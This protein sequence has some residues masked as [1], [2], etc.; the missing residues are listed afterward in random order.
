MLC[1]RVLSTF[2]PPKKRF[3]LP[4]PFTKHL[5]LFFH[6]VNLAGLI[7]LL[8]T[9]PRAWIDNQSG[10]YWSSWKSKTPGLVRLVVAK[11][12][13]A[14]VPTFQTLDDPKIIGFLKSHPLVA[15]MASQDGKVTLIR[16][17]GNFRAPTQKVEEQT[18]ARWLQ[19]AIRSGQESWAP[20]PA[21]HPDHLREVL[22]IYRNGPW[23]VAIRWSIGSPEVEQF[24]RLHLGTDSCVRVGLQRV[25]VEE[26]PAP[27]SPPWAMPPNLQAECP[28]N[29]K[30]IR[31]VVQGE[32]GSAY[33]RDWSL[34]FVPS[35]AELNNYERKLI[36]WKVM[37]YGSCLLAS[38]VLGLALFLHNRIRRR[39]KLEM[40]RMAS[41]THS[42]KTP[43]GILKLRCDSIRLGQLNRLQTEIELLRIGKEVDQLTAFINQTLQGF[44][45]NS[46]SPEKVP[47]TKEWFSALAAD[48]D[49]IFDLE[50]RR[51][52]LR[53]D[54]CSALAHPPT[55]KAA[56][57]TL[58]ENALTYGRGSVFLRTK[59]RGRCLQIHIKDQGDGL[60]SVQLGQLGIPFTRFRTPGCEGFKKEGL[61]LGLFHMSCIAQQ[62]NWGFKILSKP[63][64]GLLAILELPAIKHPSGH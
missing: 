10:K 44:K 64:H 43:L 51:L 5:N 30:T 53:L 17:G 6:F 47:I 32:S 14:Q 1:S 61:G 15:A 59:Q 26:R 34:V 45:K 58:L 41:L 29:I 37:A 49:P 55:L 2:R 39:E 52:H 24:L 7:V 35:W 63:G 19:T 23:F 40:D 38:G 25:K 57:V 54:D 36:H 18:L 9:V 28:K 56:I 46:G 22:V 16:D 21:G 27:S 13:E 33:F 3:R 20:I 31:I 42:L 62:E 12:Y 48:L 11:W 8:A 4:A 60:D 50:N